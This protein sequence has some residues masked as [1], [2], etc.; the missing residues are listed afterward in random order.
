MDSLLQ[1]YRRLWFYARHRTKGENYAEMRKYFCG[2][3]VE[4]LAPWTP[5]RGKKILDVG[6]ANGEFCEVLE[7]TFGADA[8]NVDLDPGSNAWDKTVTSPA[9]TLP[10]PAASFDLVIARGLLEHIPDNEQ[11][12]VLQEM[13]RVCRPGGWGYV[14]IPPWYNQHAGHFLKPFHLFPF[15]IA[16]RLRKVFFGNWVDGTSYAS[17]G[18]YK[19][20]ARRME[21]LLHQSGFTIIAT[22]DTHFRNHGLTRI[23]IAREVMVPAISY[24]L[25][26][27]K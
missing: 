21:R 14:T 23:P 17:V 22:R 11:A 13:F 10:F 16:R 18:L 8:T 3:L 26:K 15:A 6:G 27:P 25:Q 7:T 20:T 5:V 1:H 9:T 19:I 24:I 2:I 12:T 4:E